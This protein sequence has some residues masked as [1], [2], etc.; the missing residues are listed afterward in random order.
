MY[1]RSYERTKPGE[2]RPEVFTVAHRP[3]LPS[4]LVEQDQNKKNQKQEETR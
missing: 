4:I 1:C 2:H 3:T